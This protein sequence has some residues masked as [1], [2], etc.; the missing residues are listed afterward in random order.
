[1]H[2]K[3]L[4]FI[5]VFLFLLPANTSADSLSITQENIQDAVNLWVSDPSGAEA[6][7]GHIS[8]WD[9]SQ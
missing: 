9:V 6:I 5:T 1:M 2:K 7:Y 3:L 8:N 4:P